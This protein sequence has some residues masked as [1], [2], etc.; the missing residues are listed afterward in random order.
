MILRP[1]RSTRTATLLPYT[2]LHRSESSDS[3][4]FNHIQTL[5]YIILPQ[6]F[7]V[8]IPPTVG[9]LVQIVKNSSY[10]VVIGFF[11]LTYSA[12]IVN[13]STFKPFAVFTVAALIYFILCY[14]DRKSTRL[15]SIH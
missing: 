14:P 13:N 1:P 12:K 8:A 6:A 2:T 3:L 11:D 15:N 5:T 4:A 9:F 10:A 7:R